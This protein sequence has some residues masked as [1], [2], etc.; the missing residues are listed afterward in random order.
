MTASLPRFAHGSL[1]RAGE[2]RTVRHTVGSR[3]SAGAE[4]MRP[5][6]VANKIAL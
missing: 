2:R 1:I 6:M 5:A 3:H 4:V